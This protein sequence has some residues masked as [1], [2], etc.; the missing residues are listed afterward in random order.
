MVPLLSSKIFASAI[1]LLKMLLFVSSVVAV[2][3]IE[4]W[5]RGE[6]NSW[7]R[8]DGRTGSEWPDSVPRFIWFDFAPIIWIGLIDFVNADLLPTILQL[9]SLSETIICLFK[10]YQVITIVSFANCD[11]PIPS[12]NRTNLKY[13]TSIHSNI[14]LKDD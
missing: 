10:I 11:K 2:G 6:K 3:M 13:L 4:Q 7:E 5:G 12:P 8:N 1:E 14:T 9:L